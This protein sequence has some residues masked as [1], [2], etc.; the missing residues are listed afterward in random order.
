MLTTRQ[1][2]TDAASIS[3]T[4]KSKAR[5]KERDVDTD[6][7]PTS[8]TD[9][10]KTK[11]VEVDKTPLSAANKLTLNTKEDMLQAPSTKQGMSVA[12]GDDAIV[13]M[14]SGGVLTP[15]E[16]LLI[17][18]SIYIGK[19]HNPQILWVSGNGGYFKFCWTT[20]GGVEE[21]TAL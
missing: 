5:A 14:K 13:T 7:T 4:G 3:A 12:R 21:S 9:K 11:A 6:K 18:G 1:G 15:L 19:R 20:E 8:A 10:G 2:K 17:M 16:G